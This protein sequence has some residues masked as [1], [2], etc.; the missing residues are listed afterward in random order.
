MARLSDRKK[1]RIVADYVEDGNYRAVGRKH[2]V[3]ANTVKN[4]VLAHPD[5]AQK[6]AQKK[7]Q[8]ESDILAEL[9]SRAG[10]VLEF[11]DAGLQRLLEVVKDCKDPQRLAMAM[12]ILI[13]K[14]T[15]GRELGFKQ[16]EVDIRK[17]EVAVKEA[18]AAKESDADNSLIDDWLEGIENE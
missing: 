7:K 16:D 18:L 3:S 9:D 4:L 15:R 14:Q 6:C 8:I 1:K 5:V 10:K 11:Y 12:G 2:N 17:R 13:D